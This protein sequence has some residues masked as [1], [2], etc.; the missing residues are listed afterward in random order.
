MR[1]T[2]HAATPMRSDPSHVSSI[3]EAQHSRKSL[4]GSPVVLE[5]QTNDDRNVGQSS[6]LST[7]PRNVLLPLGK[8]DTCQT[9]PT[10]GK[11]EDVSSPE[12]DRPTFEQQ[13]A[14]TEPTT[15][16]STQ[17][18]I[19]PPESVPMPP[20]PAIIADVKGP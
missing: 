13:A 18:D 17:T 1:A 6:R 4:Y 16:V 19:H 20:S 7:Q 11:R 10:D 9:L 3:A 15:G 8:N 12:T 14:S 5:P 2:E